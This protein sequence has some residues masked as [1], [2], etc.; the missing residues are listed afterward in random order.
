MAGEQ[1]KPMTRSDEKPKTPEQTPP[2]PF[3]QVLA[4]ELQ[5]IQG[6]RGTPWTAPTVDDGADPAAREAERV[7]VLRQEALKMDLVGLALSGGG[8]RSATFCL[9]VLQA[10]GRL[11]L[12]RRLDYL[13]TVSGGGYIGGWLAAWLRRE[14]EAAAADANPVRNVEMQLD[15]DHTE[16][17][18]ADRWRTAVQ[19]VVLDDEPETIRHLRA[20]SNYLAPRPGV[21][22]ADGW[23]LI[24][25][26]LRNFL[27]NLVV[28]LCAL[29]CLLSLVVVAVK[30]GPFIKR[31]VDARPELGPGVL[32]AL[33][34]LFAGL[35][36]TASHFILR[37]LTQAEAPETNNGASL[38]TKRRRLHTLILIP[39]FLA[40]VVVFQFAIAFPSFGPALSG[41][42]FAAGFALF[43]GLFASR[44]MLELLRLRPARQ[45]VG[46]NLWW[47]ISCLAA[48]ALGGWGVYGLLRLLSAI[49]TPEESA[50]AV[51]FGPPAFLALFTLVGFVQVGLLGRQDSEAQ[52]EWWSSLG[53]WVLMY[54]GGW[55]SLFATVCFGPYLVLAICGTDRADV[56]TWVRGGGMVAAWVGSIYGGLAAARAP[57]TGSGSNGNRSAWLADL[58]ARLTPA[59]FLIGLVVLVSLLAAV[60][61]LHMEGSGPL[62]CRHCYLSVLTTADGIYRALGVFVVFL[63]AAWFAG[64]C[65][66]VNVFSLQAM[67]AN[68]LVRCYLG[69]SRRKPV[70]GTDRPAGAPMNSP[71]PPRS[72]NPVTGFDPHDDLALGELVVAPGGPYRGPILLVNTALNLVRG[73]ELAWQE[74][75]AESFVLT[76]WYCGCRTTGYRPTAR[77][78]GGLTLGTAMSI[79]GAAVSPNSGFHS[80]TA[81]TA[82]L[83]VF[84][85]RLGAWLGNP[86]RATW[87]DQGPRSGLLYLLAEALG[88]T[89]DQ[90]NYVYLSDG[91]HFE[92]LGVYELIRR[93]CRYIVVCD[94]GADP[95]FL[96]EDLGNLIRKVRVDFGVRIDLDVSGLRPGPDGRAS[97]HLAVGRIYYGD[98]DRG[99]NDPKADEAD[100]AFRYDRQEGLIFYLKT[101]LT[102]DEPTDLENQVRQRP[103]FPNDPTV[104]QFFTESQFE[105]Y[106][107][108]GYHRAF[109][110]LASVVGL[111]ATADNRALFDALYDRWYPPPPDFTSTYLELNR[112]YKG[113]QADLRTDPNL[114]WLSVELGVGQLEE[115]GRDEPRVR[116]AER[117]MAA[118]ML[119]LMENAWF[120]LHLERYRRHPIHSGWIGVFQHWWHSSA[121]Q[122]NWPTLRSEFSN[123]FRKFLE[124]ELEGLPGADN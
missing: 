96:L 70:T 114:R 19:G 18:G 103:P 33:G 83:T 54:A 60:V 121:I 72:P 13:S 42:W 64:R 26:Y 44:G 106:R 123:D 122:A 3:S 116:A 37:S 102:G 17:A 66:D 76:P 8:I 2:T 74:R 99:N 92:N 15:P 39:L 49:D 43:H 46:E 12:V 65:V 91:G 93:R 94:A 75:K 27:L 48:G 25:L 69:A 78:S 30:V 71:P 55:A 84:D 117:R 47:V 113:V 45:A 109:T 40:S 5:A 97:T 118:Q 104:N 111:H 77:Y 28:L 38:R 86:R 50:L 11:G 31:S 59:V 124:D 98:V 21:F 32:V 9:G 112:V 85:A 7:R 115:P 79:S 63:V 61:S 36:F 4:E 101:G 29:L 108:L 87:T 68:R 22:S 62:D 56:W 57:Q 119:T 6:R 110:A 82:L 107:A 52:R 16:Q 51:T 10:L 58:V 24:A 89:D 88:R 80:S 73:E 23:V 100:P 95:T 105:S 1:E 81:V 120:G 90:D 14:G 53:G 41:W 35:L 20:Y 67:Y 34:A